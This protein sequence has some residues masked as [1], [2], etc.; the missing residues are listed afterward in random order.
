MKIAKKRKE[1]IR[2]TCTRCGKSRY[3]KFMKPDMFDTFL[4]MQHYW[5]CK[6]CPK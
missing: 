1:K 3:E 2:H 4:K 5:K 6:K